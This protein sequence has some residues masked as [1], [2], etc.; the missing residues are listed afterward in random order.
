MMAHQVEVQQLR[1]RIGDKCYLNV[2]TD[3]L[4]IGVW[5]GTFV[6][7]VRLFERGGTVLLMQFESEQVMDEW[8]EKNWKHWLTMT[9]ISGENA[10]ETIELAERM[11]G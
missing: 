8:I 7:P 9:T 3:D 10:G 1:S 4:A 5:F 2:M 6:C 11:A